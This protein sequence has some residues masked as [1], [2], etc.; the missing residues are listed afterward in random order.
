MIQLEPVK[1]KKKAKHKIHKYKCI[2]M[3]GFS[4]VETFSSLPWPI[5][6]YWINGTQ[7]AR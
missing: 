2:R 5:V 1:K 3:F 4:A 6:D 7:L